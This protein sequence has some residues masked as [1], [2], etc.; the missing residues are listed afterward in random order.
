MKKHIGVASLALGV[1][2]FAVP[3]G[4]TLADGHDGK[5]RIHR[6]AGMHEAD[7]GRML[8]HLTRGLELDETQQQEVG[9][10]VTAAA[11]EMQALHDR[12]EANRT[13]MRELDVNDSNYNA[14]LSDLAAEKGAIA[15]EQALL[16]GRLRA[17]ITAILTPEQRQELADKAGK[18]RDHF[19]D[20]SKRRSRS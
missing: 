12:S 20:R 13:Q 18:L 8:R 15:A 17:D 4:P 7:P 3:A 16:H 9:N 2:L 6:S 5:H 1:A 11:P 10:I 19:E 14:R